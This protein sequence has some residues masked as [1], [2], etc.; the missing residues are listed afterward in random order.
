MIDRMAVTVDLCESF[1]S[2]LKTVSSEMFK[3][4]PQSTAL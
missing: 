2:G 3:I 1:K 4:S